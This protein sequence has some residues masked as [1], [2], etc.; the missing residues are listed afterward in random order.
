MLSWYL[1]E[2]L[3]P[4]KAPTKEW[5][6]PAKNTAVIEGIMN[7]TIQK[8]QDVLS[9]SMFTIGDVSKFLSLRKYE[10]IWY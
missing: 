2:Q 9:Q 5:F 4:M 1:A 8:G 3:K 10:V 6:L 7:A